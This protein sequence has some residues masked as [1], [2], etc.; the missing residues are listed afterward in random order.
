[1]T[2]DEHEHLTLLRNQFYKSFSMMVGLAVSQVPPH[3][4]DVFLA[5]LQDQTSVYGSAYVEYI[6][7]PSDLW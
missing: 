3:L 1:M 5:M 6:T 4:R 7:D 2:E